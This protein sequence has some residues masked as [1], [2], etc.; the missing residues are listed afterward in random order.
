MRALYDQHGRALLDYARM[1]LGGDRG[2]AEDVV[3]E[4]LLRAWRHPETVNTDR[5]LRGWLLTV[6]RNLAFDELRSR[7]A[8]P[9]E[10][11]EAPEAGHEDREL[12]RVLVAYELA[13]AL[14]SL[15]PDHRAVI[16]ALYYR[17]LSVAEAAEELGVPTGTVKSRA[18]YALRA[19]RTA[20]E[21]RGL[22]P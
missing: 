2:R 1:L 7:R 20:C 6:V 16:S 5:P 9:H 17:D 8:R 11:P 18:H 14:G 4:A 15:S 22:L 10:V 21:E 13:E 12:D 19:L 3:Q